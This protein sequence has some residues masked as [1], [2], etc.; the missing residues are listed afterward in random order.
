MIRIYVKPSERLKKTGLRSFLSHRPLY[1]ELVLAAKKFGIVNAVAHHTHY[2]YSNNGK[3]QAAIAEIG[4]PE[5]TI[6][7]ELIGE[8]IQLETFCRQ[9][10]E[11]L[12]DKVI[13]YKHLE[14]WHVDTARHEIAVEAV[15]GSVA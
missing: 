15:Q 6:C 14:R 3:V 10:G 1:R 4:N 13:V 11:A 9:Q 2:G 8:R 12:E 5:L 7:V